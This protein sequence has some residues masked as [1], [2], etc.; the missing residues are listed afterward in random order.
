LLVK[1]GSGLATLGTP[2]SAGVPD[3]IAR[4]TLVLPYNDSEAIETAF[5]TRGAEIAG[6]IIEPVA[7]N[8]GCVPPGNGYLQSLRKITSE[9]GS[10]LIF[11]EVMTGFRVAYGGAQILYDIK[12][13]LTCLAKIIGGGMPLGAVGGISEVMN[14][15]APIG[16]VYQAGTL[17]GNPLA[18]TAGLLTLRIIRELTPYPELERLSAKLESG[19]TEVLNNVGIENCSNRVGSMMTTFFNKG[20]VTDWNSAAKS[21]TSRYG[22]YFR[23]MLDEGV[24][25]APSQYECAF[26]SIA[27]TDEIIDKTISA[28]ERAV[29]KISSQ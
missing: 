3:D 27:H 17:S 22:E 29:K 28:T 20:P 21:S 14:S 9:Y 10:L 15:L 11:D 24:Y 4:N 23:A 1:A 18:V 19:I 7:G 12:P 26:I 16:P 6:V 13:D 8:M 2:D 5:K 25:L